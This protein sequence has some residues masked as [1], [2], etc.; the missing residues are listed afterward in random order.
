MDNQTIILE[1]FLSN[2]IKNKRINHNPFKF[3][4][5]SNFS[6]A[7]LLFSPFGF[8]E[9]LWDKEVRCPICL[10]RVLKAAKPESCN[11]AYCFL[12]LKKWKKQS[13]KCPIC[14]KIFNKI[15]LIDI[16]S[17]NITSQMDLFIK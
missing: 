2:L 10:G 13:K 4:Q 12:C 9:D 1:N 17:P 14:R 6:D 8:F 11:H 3:K 7:S 16:R 5:N 15:D